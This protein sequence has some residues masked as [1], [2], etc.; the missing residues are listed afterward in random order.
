MAYIEINYI[1]IINTWIDK[2][3]EI[4]WIINQE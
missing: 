1:E 4:K 3:E 2:N